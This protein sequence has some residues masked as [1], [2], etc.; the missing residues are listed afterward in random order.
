[1]NRVGAARIPIPIP[2]VPAAAVSEVGGAY[3]A[4]G[5]G[6]FWPVEGVADGAVVSKG[7]RRVEDEEE[8]LV[9]PLLV[10]PTHGIFPGPAHAYPPFRRC[11]LTVRGV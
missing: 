3:G 2:L 5:E 6:R 11:V 1:M 10:E 8:G 4:G 7:V 9:L